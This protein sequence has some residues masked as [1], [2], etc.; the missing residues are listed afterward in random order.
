MAATE[1]IPALES[2]ITDA[3]RDGD[4]TEALCWAAELLGLDAV[5]LLGE[6]LDGVQA[7][8]FNKGGETGIQILIPAG[9]LASIRGEDVDAYGC[10]S[11]EIIVDAYGCRRA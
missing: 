10:E 2:A 8:T 1:T 4:F 3:E 9:L 6:E 7:K 5:Q 11:I